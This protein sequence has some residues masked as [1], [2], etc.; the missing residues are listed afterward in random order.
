VLRGVSSAATA[1]YRL[2]CCELGSGT[3]AVT[4]TSPGRSGRMNEDLV[5]ADDGVMIVLDG[6]GI[7]GT[8]HICRHGVAWYSHT[9]GSLLLRRLRKEGEIELAAALAD[10]I[11]QVASQHRDTGGL[12][13]PSSPRQRSL[14]PGSTKSMPTTSCSRTRT[15]C[16]TSRLASRRRF[17]THGNSSS[18]GSALLPFVPSGLAR[19]STSGDGS[20][21][22]TSCG[23]GAIDQAGTGSPRRTQLWRLT[24]SR[25]RFRWRY[26]A[27]L[28]S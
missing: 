8:E 18:A 26:V 12:A 3:R 4:A 11:D 10:A 5:G 2:N 22:L 16:W 28:H 20:S 25:G 19:P 24:P 27:V 1:P 6:A 17:P 9:L 23:V 15:S 7:P 21:P 13:H 14:S